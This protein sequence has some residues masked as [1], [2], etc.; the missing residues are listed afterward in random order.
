MQISPSNWLKDPFGPD[1]YYS[2]YNKY[3][4]SILARLNNIEEVG[5]DISNAEFGIALTQGTFIYEADKREYANKIYEHPLREIL[6]KIKSKSS[7]LR[8]VKYTELDS[9][10]YYVPMREFGAATLR[11]RINDLFPTRNERLYGEYFYKGLC[12]NGKT[13]DECKPGDAA[14]SNDFVFAEFNTAQEAINYRNFAKSDVAAFYFKHTQVT[15]IVNLQDLISVN[16]YTRVWTD[17]DLCD[18]FDIT[19]EE[20]SEIEAEMAQ[21]KIK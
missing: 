1:K 6:L 21:Y 13:I 19:D 4:G 11:G 20:W 18:Y 5:H 17:D 2:C 16:D 12:S 8:F 14:A 7:H 10:H 3:K 15:M 9:V